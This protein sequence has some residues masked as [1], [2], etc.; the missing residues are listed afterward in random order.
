MSSCDTRTNLWRRI[1]E[2]SDSAATSGSLSTF[3]AKRFLAVSALL[4]CAASPLSG[5]EQSPP[6]NTETSEPPAAPEIEPPAK[7][8]T[9]SNPSLEH[10]VQ[11][12]HSL[13]EALETATTR[14]TPIIVIFGA[15]WCGPCRL[16]E[17]EIEA[18]AVQKEL[19]RWVPVHLDVD[20]EEQIAGTMAVTAIPALR[21][22]T[23][24]GRVVGQQNGFMKADELTLWLSEQ[25]VSATDA[26]SEQ[27]NGALNS[28]T[29][30]SVLK[31]F[32]SRE[33]TIRE[34][35]I[36]RVVPFPELAAAHVVAGFPEASLSERLAFLDV[37]TAWE[38]PIDGLDPWIPATVTEE[39]IGELE[40][41]LQKKE[42][43]DPSDSAELSASEFV[44]AKRLLRR[45]TTAD[46]ADASACREQLARIG[47][48]VLPMI[49]E[50]IYETLNDESRSRLSMARYRVAASIDLATQWPDG[51]AQL[52]SLEFNE[53]AAAAHELGSRAKQEDETLL[54]ELVTDPA[55][56]IREISLAAMKRIGGT[57]LDGPLVK[58]LD[59]PNPNVKA[60]VLRHL[61]DTKSEVLIPAISA[62]ISRETDTDLVVHAVRCLR[63]ISGAKAAE[64]LLPLTDH[65]SWRVRAEAVEGINKYLSRTSGNGASSIPTELRNNVST[66]FLRRIDDEDGFVV[67]KVMGG[68]DHISTKEKIESDKLLTALDRAI[69]RHP[70][71]APVI[72]S[73]ATERHWQ[74]HDFSDTLRTY[75][76]HEAPEIRAA[77]IF[78]LV[79][80][81]HTEAWPEL[82]TLLTDE[83]A[84]V[85]L[86]AMEALG[87][88]IQQQV[89]R[90]VQT[91]RTELA[92]KSR[93]SDA[94]LVAE[95]DMD[96]ILPDEF[97][98]ERKSSFLNSIVDL[99][100]G[101]GDETAEIKVLAQ[102]SEPLIIPDASQYTAEQSDE[103]F[104]KVIDDRTLDPSLYQF[105]DV[106]KRH[107]S[108]GSGLEQFAAARCL[109][110]LG[111]PEGIEFLLQSA[112]SRANMD[113]LAKLFPVLPWSARSELF[114]ELLR[115]AK[116]PDDR[117]L[118][119]RRFTQD[120]DPRSTLTIWALLANPEF[121][122]TDA[123]SLFIPL[124]YS[125]PTGSAYDSSEVNAV[126]KAAML[127]D[128]KAKA[129]E[130]IGGQRLIGLMMLAWCKSPDIADT[131][132]ALAADVQLPAD[133]RQVATQYCLANLDSATAEKKALSLLAD[134][135]PAIA[136]TAVRFLSMGAEGIHHVTGEIHIE[137]YPSNA[138][139]TTENLRAPEGLTADQVRPFLQSSRSADAA[140]AAHLLAL[141]NDPRGLPRLISYW[142]A[143]QEDSVAE[144]M[145]YQ[146]ITATDD[147][148]YVGILEELYFSMSKAKYP[149][150]MADFYR[151]I[152]TM[153]GP[154]ISALRKKI[155]Q[156]QGAQKLE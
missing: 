108:N 86:A 30:R 6:T 95:T 127:R 69:E 64:S 46:A 146:G 13:D 107:L 20:H 34:A 112:S 155:Y 71:L 109:A 32:R 94:P 139:S 138:S 68:L 18:D 80:H 84:V 39:R 12:L 60:A 74:D 129:M 49:R 61:G 7:S 101:P 52:A 44:E 118:V 1:R 133:V 54:A 145:L 89:R 58:M 122:L 65:A 154:R 8:G 124:R 4:L 53:R 19:E 130:G 56:L 143:N 132:E 78:E 123:G 51:L 102:P 128:G 35:A 70:G 83:E 82:Q 110:V 3:V 16:L 29:V 73:N 121:T 76:G 140:S 88:E 75:C 91:Q 77:A 47:I 81:I 40:E 152:R 11:W 115:T 79:K 111:N 45:L 41:W 22:L 26:E 15:D 72:F 17:T 93:Q 38:A 10:Q 134:S 119:A 55:P 67:G 141:M 90:A 5:D 92:A 9:P 100:V 153:S 37:L 113:S 104:I 21:I 24:D 59:D 2:H 106:L 97:P 85:R 87:N 36:S 42:F 14:R 57:R 31:E 96:E 116:S 149:R 125:Y 148:Q 151:T 135:E 126:T 114:E 147:Q 63:E 66:Q 103:V 131:A 28:K 50:A 137:Y 142:R 120:C 136:G 156:E 105:D 23:P 33:S 117:A 99:L 98:P 25:F 62:F 144:K 43:P 48:D 150:N 27:Q